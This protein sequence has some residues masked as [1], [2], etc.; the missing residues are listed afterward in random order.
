MR[1]GATALP[2]EQTYDIAGS[3]GTSSPDDFAGVFVRRNGSAGMTALAR[4]GTL[5]FTSVSDGEVA[6]SFAFDGHSVEQQPRSLTVEGHFTAVRA[7]EE[8]V[9]NFQF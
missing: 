2:Q 7:D 4:S 9:P 6:G 3:S 8:D 1:A 5:T